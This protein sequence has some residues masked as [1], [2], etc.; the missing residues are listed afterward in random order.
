[1]FAAFNGKP[2]IEPKAGILIPVLLGE[3]EEHSTQKA[4]AYSLHNTGTF[5]VVGNQ[6]CPTLLPQRLNKR[7]LTFHPDKNNVHKS[8][9]TL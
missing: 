3:S 7:S 2:I 4:M 1:M 9:F 8:V 5:W 6:F